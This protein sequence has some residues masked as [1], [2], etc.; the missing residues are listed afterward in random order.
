MTET[1]LTVDNTLVIRSDA[2]S[3]DFFHIYKKHSSSRL[4]FCTSMFLDDF[5]EMF[6]LPKEANDKLHKCNPGDEFQ[7]VLNI[8]MEKESDVD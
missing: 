2:E 8:E 6:G 4:Q 1:K 3:K 5:S 7:I